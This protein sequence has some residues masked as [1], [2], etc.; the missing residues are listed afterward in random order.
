MLKLGQKKEPQRVV[1]RQAVGTPGR[2]GYE[3]EAFVVLAPITPPMRRRAQRVALRLAGEVANVTDLDLDQIIDIGELGA[4]ELIRLGVIEWGGI[5]ETVDGTDVE[6]PLT[7]DRDTRFATA[8]SDER[9]SGTIDL[10]LDDDELFARLNEEYCR[11]DAVRRAE[12]NG[13]SALPSGTGKAGTRGKGTASSAARPK[14]TA[15]AK[16]ARTGKTSSKPKPAKA[17]GRS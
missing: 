16:S 9:P 10:L 14:R 7:P 6:L 15:A 8:T 17:P 5:G 13:L 1:L 12:K 2:K 3:P 11:P 4:R